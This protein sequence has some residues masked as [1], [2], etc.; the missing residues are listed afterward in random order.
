MKQ[1]EKTIKD[2]LNT[3]KEPYKSKAIQ[4]TNKDI[5]EIQCNNITDA[6]LKMFEWESSEEGDLFWDELF[7]SLVNKGI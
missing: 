5:L 3:L 2:W 7:E 6:L 4:Q 1:K